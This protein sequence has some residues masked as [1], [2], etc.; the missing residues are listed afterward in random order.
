MK[1]ALF[2]IFLITV[3]AELPVQ[4]EFENPLEFFVFGLW[5]CF[6]GLV[7]DIFRSTPPTPYDAYKTIPEIIMTAGYA[8]ETH[9]VVTEDGY[10]N[11]AWRIIGKLNN[12][13][14]DPHPE[15]K[16]AVILQ[17]GLID[18]SATWLIPNKSISLS[19]TLVE[20]GYDVW[21][22]NSRGTVNSY[23]HMH[24]ETHNVRK[25]SSDFFRF[26]FGDMAQYDLPAYL[27]YILKRSDYDKVFY[28]GHSQGTTQFFAAADVL[29]G[30]EDRIAGFVALAPVMYIGNIYNPF[31]FLLAHSGLTEVLGFFKI[32]N[33]FI[34]PY[35]V[36]PVMRDFA[37]Y[38]RTFI[39]RLLGLAMGIDEEVRTDLGRMP[40]MANHEPGGT[41]YYN[42]MHWK[43]NYIQG[44]FGKFDWGREENMRRYGQA[45]APLYNTTHIAE[46]L[47]KI[48]TIMFVGD[49]DALVAPKDLKK[50]TT[51]LKD[52]DIKFNH[53]PHYAHADLIWAITVKEN[54][55]DPAVEFIKNHTQVLIP[56]SS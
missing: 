2:L 36:D 37:V 5:Y 1:L 11:T 21:M 18:N 51:L 41:S 42:M 13:Y 30:L 10:I 43:Q 26:T 25:I 56:T 8:F 38:F 32:Y 55:F 45:K 6:T 22:T 15:K 46:T 34:L 54:V 23:E 4:A 3:S 28:V 14:G 39:W 44:N 24:P 7:T 9:K 35:F 12:T 29:D 33:F 20:E 27:D 17:H 52:T 47:G 19:F 40:V 16:P 48:P 31:M 49:N 53:I 50:L